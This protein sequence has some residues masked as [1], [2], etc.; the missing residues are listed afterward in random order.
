MW[1]NKLSGSGNFLAT[2]AGYDAGTKTYTIVPYDGSGLQKGAVSLWDKFDT[3]S[4]AYSFTPLS[5]E[6]P[7]VC[8]TCNGTTI[9]LGQFPVV[10]VD[11]SGTTYTD[12]PF[13][14]TP[15]GISK[16]ETIPGETVNSNATGGYCSFSDTMHKT[17]MIPDQ[18]Y[19]ELN[20]VSNTMRVGAGSYSIK[21]DACDVDFCS[22]TSGVGDVHVSVKRSKGEAPGTIEIWAGTTGDVLKISINGNEFL[23]VDEDRNVQIRGKD[24]NIDVNDV[25]IKCNDIKLNSNNITAKTGTIDVESKTVQVEAGS[26]NIILACGTLDLTSCGAVKM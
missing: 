26:N 1:D 15:K 23:H 10:N 22:S 20:T 9:I 14:Y 25:D 24:I 11:G 4:N 17:V 6:A 5:L 3:T 13:N 21:S 12:T 19:Q 16:S 2:I 7:C 8:T 18:L